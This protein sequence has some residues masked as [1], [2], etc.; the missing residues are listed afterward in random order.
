MTKNFSVFV[1]TITSS[2]K[3][4][5]YFIDWEKVTRMKSKF[6]IILNKLNYLLGKDDLEKEFHRLF[7]SEPDVILVFPAL[8][9]VRDIEIE[10]LDAT[11]KEIFEYSFKHKPEPTEHNAQKY[12]AFFVKTG[13]ESLFKEEG[14]KNLV[15]YVYGVEVGLDSHGRKNW[16]GSAM[17]KIIEPYVK[18]LCEENNDLDCMFQATPKKIFKKWKKQIS[19][20]E[21]EKGGEKKGIKRYDFAIYNHKTQEIKLGEANFYNTP[22]SKPSEICRAYAEVYNNLKKEGIDFI[23]ITD[24]AGWKSTLNPLEDVYNHNDYVFNLNMLKEGILR[25]LEW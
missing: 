11:T 24:G 13:L 12:Y 4:W 14:V 6:E 7:F 15:D 23:W 2:N 9:A 20:I 22:G 21:V 1:N 18:K 5:S 3:D 25:K 10:I 8:L 19:V 16:S 17:E